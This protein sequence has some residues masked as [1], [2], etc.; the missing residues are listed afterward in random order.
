MEMVTGQKVD[1]E[2]NYLTMLPFPCL[3]VI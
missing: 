1:F 3:F 2:V